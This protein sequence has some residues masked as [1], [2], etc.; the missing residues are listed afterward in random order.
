MPEAAPVTL[1][2]LKSSTPNDWRVDKS[3]CI[4]CRA[5]ADQFAEGFGF[6][7]A[8]NLAFETGATAP[9]TYDPDE[10]IQVCPS[11][12]IFIPGYDTGNPV[13]QG[14]KWPGNTSD[15]EPEAEAGADESPYEAILRPS[16]QAE[17]EPEPLPEPAVR[18]AG[19]KLLVALTMPITG[20]L[21]PRTRHQIERRVQDELYFSER[22]AAAINIVANLFL[23]AGLL[24][25]ARLLGGDTIYSGTLNGA[26]LLGFAL[27]TVEGAF[28]LLGG[29][30]WYRGREASYVLGAWYTMPLGIL[31]TVRSTLARRRIGVAHSPFAKHWHDGGAVA[32][33]RTMVNLELERDRQRRYGNVYRMIQRPGGAELIF[34][35][36]R[37]MPEHPARAAL[38]I[39]G[40]LPDYQWSLEQD[41]NTL[42]VHAKLPDGPLRTLSG[43]VNGLPLSFSKL[44][45]F[46]R[47]IASAEGRYEAQTRTLRIAVLLGG[48]NARVVDDF[49]G[50]GEAVIRAA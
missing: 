12:S 2:D 36:A 37:W 41:A 39:D 5:C 7:D 8:E 15:G 45:V 49:E 34:E 43:Q 17:P 24:V 4:G 6:D 32:E 38:G 42:R 11:D 14:G 31:A 46:D 28:R 3:T 21:P 50:V 26:A 18:T 44:V 23:Y 40:R 22:Q 29:P 48:E 13:A 35:L 25:A 27:G 30:L 47:D 33:G 16:Q 19:Q 1:E 20:A 10:V 9:G